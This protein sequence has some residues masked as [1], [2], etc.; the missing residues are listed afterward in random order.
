MRIKKLR[1]LLKEFK[2]EHGNL[3]VI[4]AGYSSDESADGVEHQS[5]MNPIHPGY[6][7]IW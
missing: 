2:D 3:E 1:K 4:I 6:A 5:R 7:R